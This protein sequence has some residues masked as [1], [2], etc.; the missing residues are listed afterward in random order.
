[1]AKRIGLTKGF[2]CIVSDEDF[3]WIGSFKWHA[4]I[5]TTDERSIQKVYAKRRRRVS[6][7]GET[8]MVYMHHEVMKRHLREQ[9]LDVDLELAG[10]YIDHGDGDSLNNTRENLWPVLPKENIPRYTLIHNQPRVKRALK[11]ARRK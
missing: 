6:E 10:K 5:A 7:P 11:K 1:M 3:E 4:S 2:H 8:A 9:G